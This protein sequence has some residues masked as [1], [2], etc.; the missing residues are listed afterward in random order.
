MQKKKWLPQVF[1]SNTTSTFV[2]QSKVKS[3]LWAISLGNTQSGYSLAN[4]DKST[5]AQDIM[6]T[7]VFNTSVDLI[8]DISMVF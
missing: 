2:C 8:C 3:T 7:Y 1:S 6:E 4:V 5:K